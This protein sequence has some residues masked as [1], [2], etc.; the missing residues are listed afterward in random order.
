MNAVR[1]AVRELLQRS[2]AFA[3]LAPDQ[4]GELA[5]NM[6]HVASRLVDPGRLIAAEFRAPLL[7]A[8]RAGRGGIES[9]DSMVAAVDFPDFVRGLIQGV[10]GAIVNASIEQ[11]KAYTELVKQ[12][13]DSVEQFMQDNLDNGAAREWL[14][15]SFPELFC[16][17]ATGLT[18]KPDAKARDWPRL[19]R[20]LGLRQ[21][22][23]A[24]DLK[25]IVQA[26]R[27][28]LARARQQQLATMLMM[29]INRIVVTNGKIG[30][31]AKRRGSRA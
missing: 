1:P 9:F 2:P 14:G 16:V 28:R 27:R 18:V 3:Q 29:G 5:R 6:V 20:A 19:N 11:M 10:F 15:E 7:T 24:A 13:S 21:R 25:R 26:A 8:V 22:A 31:R 23:T 17:G 12:A 30:V 4:R